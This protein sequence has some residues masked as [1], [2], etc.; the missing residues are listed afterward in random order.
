MLES[1]DTFS[2]QDIYVV[3][4]LTKPLLGRSS[5]ENTIAFASLAKYSST[6]GSGKSSRLTDMFSFVKSMQILT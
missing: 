2:V 4:G 5:L 1:Q 6:E 3:K